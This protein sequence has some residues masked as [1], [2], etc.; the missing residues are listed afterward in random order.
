M[1][2]LYFFLTCIV[3]T[4]FDTDYH[5]V[6]FRAFWC[7]RGPRASDLVLLTRVVFR[8]IQ[9]PVHV[10]SVSSSFTYLKEPCYDVGMRMSVPPSL[11]KI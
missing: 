7:R 5:Q 9:F 3:D 6:S 1:R 2:L 11:S 4:I 8:I 10:S